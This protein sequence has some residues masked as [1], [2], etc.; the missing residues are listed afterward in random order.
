MRGAGSWST[1]MALLNSSP[2]GRRAALRALPFLA[3]AL[4]SWPAPA[5]ELTEA[6][7]LERCQNN[8]LR[9]EEL[10]RQTA[11]I[12]VMT[13]FEVTRIAED[14][15]ALGDVATHEGVSVDDMALIRTLA[16]R[17]KF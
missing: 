17:Y 8:K 6:E 9:L 3:L 12:Q 14:V 7:R 4:L 1:A 2:S 11:A 5:A 15:L 10:N 13:P 16:G